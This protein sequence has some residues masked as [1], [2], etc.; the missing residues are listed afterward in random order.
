MFLNVD[1]VPVCWYTCSKKF[2]IGTYVPAKAKP[3]NVKDREGYTRRMLKNRI[4]IRKRSGGDVADARTHFRSD[5]FCRI[6][7]NQQWS[8]GEE[9]RICTHTYMPSQDEDDVEKE[10]LFVCASENKA[11][12]EK[13]AQFLAFLPVF[14]LHT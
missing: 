5:K 6:R 7:R 9:Q 3:G 1:A 10:R 12:K 2:I 8:G 4:R 13:H 14:N 11:G